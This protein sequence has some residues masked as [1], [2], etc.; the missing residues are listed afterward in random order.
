M[1]EFENQRKI[2]SLEDKVKQAFLELQNE[3]K[4]RDH[5]D[6]QLEE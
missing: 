2:A 5:S 6:K 1:N 3:I 4:L